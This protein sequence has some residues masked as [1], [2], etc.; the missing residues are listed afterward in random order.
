MYHA[1]ILVADRE[2][3]LGR[4]LTV[5]LSFAG[6]EVLATT[7]GTD[8]V[9][10]ARAQQP[11][12]ILV[13]F[14]LP[15]LGGVDLVARLREACDSPIVVMSGYVDPHHKDAALQAGAVEYVTKPFHTAGLAEICRVAIERHRSGPA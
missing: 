2:P 7:S 10:Q 15:D 12:L 8:A 13:D 3:A 14:S 4:L 6:F 9:E 11:D 1:R 5:E